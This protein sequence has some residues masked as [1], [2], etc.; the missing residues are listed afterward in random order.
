MGRFTLPTSAGVH[1][2]TMVADAALTANQCR[3]ESMISTLT[4]RGEAR[5]AR[6]PVL[7]HY[8]R[9]EE[10]VTPGPTGRGEG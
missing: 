6:Q 5:A 1:I 2:I 7:K 3:G 8:E 10:T 9:I 4:A